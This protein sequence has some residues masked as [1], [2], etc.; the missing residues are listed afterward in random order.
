M[1]FHS[2]GKPFLYGILPNV[3]VHASPCKFEGFYDGKTLKMTFRTGDDGK[4]TSLFYFFSR[5]Q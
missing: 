1:R 5:V 2:D 3:E 4:G